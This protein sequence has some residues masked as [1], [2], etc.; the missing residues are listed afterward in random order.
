MKTVGMN[1]NEQHEIFRLV[2]AIL[3]LGQLKFSPSGGTHLVNFDSFYSLLYDSLFKSIFLVCLVEGSQVSNRDELQIAA[4]LLGVT[5]EELEKTLCNRTVT[6]GAVGVSQRG[7]S[8]Y[9]SPLKPDLVLFCSFFLS[10]SLSLSLSLFLFFLSFFLLSL[11]FKAVSHKFFF[12]LS[13]SG[14]I[15][16]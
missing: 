16:S 8:M 13:F 6:R 15:Y 1:E 2:A 7:V 3:H 9:L 4:Q 5:P 11:L 10:F 12:C 14:C